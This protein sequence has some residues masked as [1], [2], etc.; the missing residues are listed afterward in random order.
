MYLFHFEAILRAIINAFDDVDEEV[1]ENWALPYWNY[2]PAASRK[3][4]P[5][6]GEPLLPDDSPNPLYDDSRYSDVN[7][8]KRGLTDEEVSSAGWLNE[9]FF[10]TKVSAASFGGSEGGWNH[11]DEVAGA[12]PGELEKTPHGDV[13]MFLGGDMTSF[14]AAGN[15][16]VFWLHHA[17]IDRLWE[18]WR[19]VR[20]QGGAGAADPVASGW[21]NEPFKFRDANNDEKTMTPAGVLDAAAQ[22][23]Y[24]Y[25]DVSP[26][27]APK[28]PTTRGRIVGKVEP[29]D[30]PELIPERIGVSSE[31]VVL[32]GNDATVGFALRQPEG[33]VSRAGR[34]GPA[35][36]LLNVEHIRSSGV[37][38]ATY[39]VFIDPADGTTSDEY[40]VGTLPFFGLQESSRDDA[41]HELR[42]SFDVT[43]IVDA[44]RDQDKWDANRVQVTFRPVSQAA[45]A[46]GSGA[47]VVIGSVSISYQ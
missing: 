6:F 46:E 44:L 41:D 9:G 17:N 21:L 29:G 4:P 37:P 31:D 28:P 8:G 32:A 18:V 39:R 13:H 22:L 45:A 19:G 1:K 11:W 30:P 35:R 40:Y 12:T 3:L 24:E 33:L 34:E 38:K 20:R 15:D 7:E 2:E 36:V 47:D 5:A 23:G 16:P 10:S 26:P 42:Y 27:T 14:E 43:E 25:D